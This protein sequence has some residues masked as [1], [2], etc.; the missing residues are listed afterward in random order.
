[1]KASSS[2]PTIPNL[3]G[4]DMKLVRPVLILVAAAWS[5]GLATAAGD[6]SGVHKMQTQTT[7]PAAKAGEMTDA[8]VRKVDKE[9]SKLTLKHAEIKSLDMPAMTMVFSVK[10]KTMLDAVKAG[11]K[12]KIRV[13][14]DAGKL[15]VTEMQVVK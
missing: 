11:D 1:M 7:A 10:D 12:V 15:T 13:V 4:F 2:Y 9:G 14:D 6:P 5:A 3:K 8:E